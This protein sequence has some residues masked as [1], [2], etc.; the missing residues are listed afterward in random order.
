MLLAVAEAVVYHTIVRSRSAGQ[1]TDLVLLAVPEIVLCLNKVR[2]RSA[3]QSHLNTAPRSSRGS[4]V[5]LESEEHCFC[6]A[7]LSERTVL[8]GCLEVVGVQ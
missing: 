8:V 1:R 5:P 6:G 7:L 3:G 4:L 2:S